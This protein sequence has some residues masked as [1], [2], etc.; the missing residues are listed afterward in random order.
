MSIETKAKSFLKSNGFVWKEGA[1]RLSIDGGMLTSNEQEINRFG[2]KVFGGS[3]VE[4]L[5]RVACSP[6]MSL[7]K[8]AKKLFDDERLIPLSSLMSNESLVI[9]KRDKVESALGGYNHEWA[10]KICKEWD[11]L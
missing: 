11:A 7:S 9:I 2:G 1:W 4:S 3:A 5:G 6:H 10:A 8:A